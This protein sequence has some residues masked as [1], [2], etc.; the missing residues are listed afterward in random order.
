MIE[1]IVTVLKPPAMSSSDV[2]VDV[3]KIFETK[4]VGHLGTLDPEAAGVLPVCIGRAVRLFDYL[5]DKQKTYLAE[6]AFGVAT[7]TQDAQGKVTETSN[8]VVTA[9]Q[10]DAVLPRFIGTI[11]QTPPM[12]SALK[13]NGQKLYDLALSGKEIPDK[14]RELEIASLRRVGTRG[15]NRFLIEVTCSRGTYIRTLCND[16]GE[17]LQVPAHM[18]F[19]LRTA[20]GPFTLERAYSIAELIEMKAQGR[21]AEA[22][23]SCEDAVAFLKR[24]D[25]ARDRR[26]PTVNGLPTRTNAQDG[27][28]RIYCNGFLGVGVVQN[29]DAFLKVHL[30]GE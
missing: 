6:I 27:T 22:L 30:Y 25:L 23:T 18:A 8:A 13:F 12:Y 19:L 17:V 20:S 5:V 15:M 10:L 26:K 24:I 4:R 21:L 11:V 3:R 2:V 7:D 16:I 9:E 1:G 29:G 14:S 28:Y